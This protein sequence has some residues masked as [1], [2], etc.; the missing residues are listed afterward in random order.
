[1]EGEILV[2]LRRHDAI[3]EMLP[4]IE[5]MTQP[6]IRVVFLIPYP[7]KLWS[8]LRDHWI[9]TESRSAAIVA[10]R[11]IIHEY[12]W[13]VQ[14]TLAEQKISLARDVLHKKR[15]EVIANICMSGM[16][17]AIKDHSV[18]REARLVLRAGSRYPLLNLVR[19]TLSLF[20]AFKRP[21]SPPIL[22]LY[23]GQ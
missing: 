4:Y 17:K 20:G 1:M 16:R 14:K 11:K 18:E 15:V 13:E 7:V 23:P 2:L 22:L 8:W 5:K 3:E 10:G 19:R 21:V 9:T 6:G 12:S